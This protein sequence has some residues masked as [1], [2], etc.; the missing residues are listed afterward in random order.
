MKTLTFKEKKDKEITEEDIESSKF[1][2]VDIKENFPTLYKELSGDSKSQLSSE[3]AKN[4]LSDS[5][6][7][8]DEE[9]SEDKEGSIDLVNDGEIKTT[10]KPMEQDYLRG[11]DPQAIDFIRRAKSE[12]EA[13]DILNF[14]E[15]RDEIT[16][17]DCQDLKRQLQENGLQ[18]FG[19]HKSDGYYFEFQRKKHM[20]EKMKLIGKQHTE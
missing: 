16:S 12:Q 20:E 4:I 11:F 10:E 8:D 7:S 5:I 6:D 14:L 19:D 2:E 1:T 13:I 15:N 9:H 18:S 17:E 3:E